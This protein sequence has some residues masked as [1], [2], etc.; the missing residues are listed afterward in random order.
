[1]PR[2]IK[3]KMPVRRRRY[4]RRRYMNSRKKTTIP[5]TK[6]FGF[7]RTREDLLSLESPSPGSGWLT[8]LDGQCVRTFSWSLANLPNYTEFSNLFNM[9]KLNQAIVSFFPTY[10]EINR[11]AETTSAITQSNI[12]ISVWRNTTGTPI[13]ATFTR[14]QLN[15]I[16]QKKQW[17]FPSNKKTTI[18]MPLTQLSQVYASTINT[19]YAKIRPKYISTGEPS[20]SHYGFNVAITRVDN[21][22]FGS[23]SLQLLTKEKIYLTCKQVQ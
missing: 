15:E 21:Q 17:M 5:K 1:M 7:N 6:V 16:A 12:I 23:S 11:N 20:T 10:S 4:N 2:F 19:D 8:T 22:P 14:A 13:G 18:K 3:K 9:Y